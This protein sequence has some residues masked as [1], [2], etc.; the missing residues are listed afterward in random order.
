MSD[1]G[2]Q[3]EGYNN[4]KQSYND[5]MASL[6]RF[7]EEI[8]EENMEAAITTLYTLPTDPTNPVFSRWM[9]VVDAADEFTGNYTKAYFFTVAIK[10]WSGKTKVNYMLT[11]SN[12]C[13]SLM[14]TRSQA[15]KGVSIEQVN[16][17]DDSEDSLKPGD[18]PTYY[19]MLL[20]MVGFSK[21][22]YRDF[23]NW[24]FRYHHVL[25]RGSEAHSAPDFTIHVALM[26]LRMDELRWRMMHL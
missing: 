14:N 24:Q 9:Y 7:A 15:P 13:L 8:G 12:T 11:L 22:C 20:F 21:D 26:K 19:T 23:F 25:G 6:D 1:A 16:S 3:T 2:W 5:F 17:E 18:S 4:F 10:Q